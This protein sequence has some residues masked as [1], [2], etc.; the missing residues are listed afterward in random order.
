VRRS[1][2]LNHRLAGAIAALGHGDM[3]L[4]VDA[5]FPIPRAADR[6]DLAVVRDL[7]DLRTVLRAVHR[8]LIVERVVFASEM[9]VNNAPLHAFLQEEFDGAELDGRP[10][11]RM[12]GGAALE[13]KT[14]VRTGA[15]DPW[16]NIGL[17]SGV[18]VPEW[19]SRE[20]VLMP[21]SYEERHA[22]MS[23]DAAEGRWAR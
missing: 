21:G 12:L 19:F 3:L 18:D 23:R 9:A 2:I 14:I 11:E 6:I 15:F 17:V 5:G 22:A 20:G 4:V 16:G 7:P 1:G 13:A 10:H 8:E